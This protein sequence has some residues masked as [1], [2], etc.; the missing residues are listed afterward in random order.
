MYF[1]IDDLINAL[2]YDFMTTGRY[3]DDAL[4]HI[5]GYIDPEEYTDDFE[6][7]M[8]NN[9]RHLS[10]LLD[11]FN[12]INLEE[13]TRNFYLDL[14]SQLWEYQDNPENNQAFKDVIYASVRENP[15]IAAFAIYNGDT[16]GIIEK[17]IIS[18]FIAFSED[19]SDFSYTVFNRAINDFISDNSWRDYRNFDWRDFNLQ[20]KL[21]Q[22]RSYGLLEYEDI[23]SKNGITVT[24]L[25]KSVSGLLDSFY[26]NGYAFKPL[27]YLG[28]ID[29]LI[30]NPIDT[31]TVAKTEDIQPSVD[32]VD[33]EPLL[34]P[35]EMDVM[36]PAIEQLLIEGSEPL[37]FI[38]PSDYL[39]SLLVF[40]VLHKYEDTEP[41]LEL[42]DAA[43]LLMYFKLSETE[44]SE[45]LKL[46]PPS[47]GVSNFLAVSDLSEDEEV[48]SEV[49][50]SD[51]AKILMHSKLSATPKPWFTKFEGR[52]FP[53]GIQ[54]NGN[55]EIA[56]DEERK[57][58]VEILNRDGRVS[59]EYLSFL[60]TFF[61]SDYNVIAGKVCQNG[62]GKVFY[63]AMSSLQDKGLI[64]KD[65]SGFVPGH[66]SDYAL[67]YGINSLIVSNPEYT[68][69]ERK[70]INAISSHDYVMAKIEYM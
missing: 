51:V 2:A 60:C 65:I 6:V 14:I 49:G 44:E 63:D 7:Y 62:N 47:A 58:V 18:R 30:I 3:I 22:M 52:E 69:S 26:S 38:Q 67:N 31:E 42:P 1:E 41:A 27:E 54:V 9:F 36:Y 39:S 57:N 61:A 56:L 70:I 37:G 55:L 16:E 21:E 68:D 34:E 53:Y 66:N 17:E 64:L 10:K 45:S 50:L 46:L 23:F 15:Q 29:S 40:S 25:G 4:T 24:Y 20:E 12:Y 8:F 43:K 5:T 35:S 19:T 48:K 33:V 59:N 13:E 11:S 28:R 32:D